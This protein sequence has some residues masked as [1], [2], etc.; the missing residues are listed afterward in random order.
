M[1]LDFL[2]VMLVILLVYICVY[3]LVNRV[4]K[5]IEYCAVGKAVTE[6]SQNKQAKEEE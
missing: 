3:A 2:Q 5:C 4:C 1:R 6:L